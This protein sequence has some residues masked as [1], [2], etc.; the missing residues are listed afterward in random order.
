MN[1]T[2]QIN[3]IVLLVFAAVIATAAYTSWD[4]SRA[5]EAQTRQTAK[6]VE[7][8]AYLFSQNCIVCHGNKAEGG[9]ASNRLKQAMPQ[10][11]AK[12][13]VASYPPEH[14]QQGAHTQTPQGMEAGE[15]AHRLARREGVRNGNPKAD[16][17]Q[18][19]IDRRKARWRCCRQTL[20]WCRVGS[21]ETA[22]TG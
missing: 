8:G 11:C 16:I 5:S 13:S 7:Y 9:A 2:R 15:Q 21:R 19:C 14:P 4:P 3:I 10:M 17:G 1:T 12:G 6:T 22:T 18:G 20:Q